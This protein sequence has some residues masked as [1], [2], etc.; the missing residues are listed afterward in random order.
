MV[1]DSFHTKPLLRVLQSADRY[2]VLGVSRRQVKLLEGNRDALDEVELKT[3]PRRVAEVR[4]EEQT[5]QTKDVSSFGNELGSP[6]TAEGEAAMYQGHGARHDDVAGDA[7]RFFRAVDREILEHHSRP[8]G[9]PLILAGLPENQ[10][11]FRQVSHNPFLIEGGIE[12]DPFSL[13]AEE[14]R[15]RAWRVAEPQYLA[16]LAGLVEAFGVAKS[17][18]LGDDDPARVAEAAATGRVATLMIE[19]DRQIPGRIDGSTGR[20][21]FGAPDGQDVDD[22]L[23]DLAELVLRM[24]GQV[25]V[26]PADQ[27]P[28]QTGVAATYRF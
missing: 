12:I 24:G 21:E 23:D 13:S 9:L 25:Q 22:L 7:E 16:R 28:T 14:L 15:E 17:R 4:G 19:A 11:Y 27:M 20:V 2:Q 8:S 1:A 5:A 3:I 10:A 18:G 26:V 6:F